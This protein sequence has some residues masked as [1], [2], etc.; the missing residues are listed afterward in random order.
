ML[1][2][3]CMRASSWSNARMDLLYD[4]MNNNADSIQVYNVACIVMITVNIIDLIEKQCS[5]VE[6]ISSH[7]SCRQIT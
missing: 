1:P 4:A 6:N 7:T 2:I 3:H 5:D